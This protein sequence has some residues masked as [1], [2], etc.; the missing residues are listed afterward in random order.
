MPRTLAPY[1]VRLGVGWLGRRSA[2]GEVNWQRFFGPGR[3]EA[4]DPDDRS[5]AGRMDL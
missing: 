2:E 5:A 4:A 1:Y 3:P